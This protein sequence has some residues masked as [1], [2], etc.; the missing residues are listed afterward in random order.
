MKKF[1]LAMTAMLLAVSMTACASNPSDSGEQKLR[2]GIIQPAEHAAL[3]SAREGFVGSVKYLWYQI[4]TVMHAFYPLM[5][6]TAKRSRTTVEA[7][8]LR[9]Y[10]YAAV[11]KSV[12]KLKLSALKVTDNDLLFLAISLLWISLAILLSTLI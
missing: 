1:G 7:L 2:I 8:E 12:K 10:R 11:N 4:K 6:N 9:G 5:L 3:D